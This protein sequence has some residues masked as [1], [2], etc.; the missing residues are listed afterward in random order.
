MSRVVW[1]AEEELDELE[2]RRRSS[3]RVKARGGGP[4]TRRDFI[5]LS[6]IDDVN[7]VRVGKVT[8]MD[9]ALEGAA[10]KYRL[11][12]DRSKDWK[13]KVHLGV[14]RNG[15]KHW[16]FRTGRAEAT[17]NMIRRLTR[18]P[19]EQKRKIVGGQLIPILIYRSELHQELP[20]EAKRLLRKLVR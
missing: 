1:K 17:F 20:E 15:R 8:N 13:D 18:L 14:N 11:T 2:G 19:P 6:Y 4:G 9:R 12:W 5:P 16:K 10:T 3:K 7:S